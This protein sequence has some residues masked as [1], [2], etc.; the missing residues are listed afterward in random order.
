MMVKG[1]REL[2]LIDQ[3]TGVR[4]VGLIRTARCR[5]LISFPGAHTL[6]Q[7]ARVENA[8]HWNRGLVQ[9][10]TFVGPTTRQSRVAA[11]DGLLLIFGFSFVAQFLRVRRVSL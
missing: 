5:G 10:R 3:P 4:T 6:Q 1:L 2:V 8:T 7:R 11:Q 9:L